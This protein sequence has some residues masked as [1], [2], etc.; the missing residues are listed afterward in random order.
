LLKR[1]VGVPVP[2][3]LRAIVAEIWGLVVGAGSLALAA[4]A[5]VLGAALL[6]AR[7]SDSRGWAALVLVGGIVAALVIAVAESRRDSSL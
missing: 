5:A 2:G 1:P 3:V 4:I 7:L 6:A